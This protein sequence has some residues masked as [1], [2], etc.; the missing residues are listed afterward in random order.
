MLFGGGAVAGLAGL[1]EQDGGFGVGFGGVEVRPDVFELGGDVGEGFA[2]AGGEGVGVGGAGATRSPSTW[3]ASAARRAETWRAWPRRAR[4]WRA[5]V[6]PMRSPI[7]SPGRRPLRAGGGRWGGRRRRPRSRPGPGGDRSRSAPSWGGRG[8]RAR[9]AS[10]RPALARP[11]PVP[12][13]RRCTATGRCRCA[14]AVRRECRSRRLGERRSARGLARGEERRATSQ[15]R[16]SLRPPADRRP[17]RR[18]GEELLRI[19]ET[20]RVDER[21]GEDSVRFH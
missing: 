4:P 18:R 8:H 19:V 2:V 1:A 20:A 3:P 11:A 10:R 16:L 21:N 6:A 9:R 5:L 13:R 12:A 14:R 7:S 17:D 15:R